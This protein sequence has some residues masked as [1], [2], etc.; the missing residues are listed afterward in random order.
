MQ[1]GQAT[2][3]PL[4]QWSSLCSLNI[5]YDDPSLARCLNYMVILQTLTRRDRS[6]LLSHRLHSSAFSAEYKYVLL[7]R[8]SSPGG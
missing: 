2:L 6:G 3:L 7:R 8:E 5:R 1:V 4:K